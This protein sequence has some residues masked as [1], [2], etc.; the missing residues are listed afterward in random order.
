MVFPAIVAAASMWMIAPGGPFIVVS[1]LPTDH[2]V[3]ALCLALVA[4][5]VMQRGDPVD[6]RCTIASRPPQSTTSSATDARRKR[7]TT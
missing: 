2:F 1:P 3:V 4:E 6:R 5:V 7:T